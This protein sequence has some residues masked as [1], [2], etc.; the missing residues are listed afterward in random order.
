M[1]RKNKLRKNKLEYILNHIND[2]SI[3]DR[4]NILQL[5]VTD[6]GIDCV[7]DSADGCRIIINEIGNGTLDGIIELIMIVLG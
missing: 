6:L 1:K 2:L 4:K 3:K 7:N 5:I